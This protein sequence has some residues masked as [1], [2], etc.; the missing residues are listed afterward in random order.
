MASKNITRES[1]SKAKLNRRNTGALLRASVGLQKTLDRQ[2]IKKRFFGG[3][4]AF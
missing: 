1:N 2:L 3:C 4:D